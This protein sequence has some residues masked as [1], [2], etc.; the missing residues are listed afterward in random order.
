MAFSADQIEALIQ[1][2]AKKHGLDPNIFRRQLVQESGLNPS[3]VNQRSGA[4]G[5]A[6][7]MP[8]TARGFGINPMDP[9]QAIPA[10]AAYM[11]Q[12][13][14]AHG[15]DYAHALAAYNWGPGNVAKKGLAAAPPETVN[16]IASIMGNK[17]MQASAQV[18]AP[19]PAQAAPDPSATPPV[20]LSPDTLAQ[21]QAQ[22]VAQQAPMP[23]PPGGTSLADLLLSTGK[24]FQAT[25]DLT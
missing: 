15:G 18:P 19:A 12:N 16:Y 14:N 7:F 21:L 22:P 11:R 13:L 20:A 2:A 8:G 23:P 5:I 25:Q 6:Q 1:E 9:A 4:A 10:A 3:I 17:P 24:K